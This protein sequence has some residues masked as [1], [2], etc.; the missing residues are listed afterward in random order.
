MPRLPNP[1]AEIVDREDGNAPEVA[2]L[3][4][5]QPT[6][7][8]SPTPEAESPEPEPSPSSTPAPA[9]DPEPDPEPPVD[10]PTPTPPSSLVPALNLKPQLAVV[11]PPSRLPGEPA[12]EISRL[13]HPA[14]VY[15][16]I[17]EDNQAY[18][19]DHALVFKKEYAN[20]RNPGRTEVWWDFYSPKAE[21]NKTRRRTSASIEFIYKS[22]A[23]RACHREARYQVEMRIYD[24]KHP[25]GR[26]L[27]AP[28]QKSKTHL[29]ELTAYAGVVA[30]DEGT[31]HWIERRDGSQLSDK[32]FEVKSI[33]GVPATW[34][35]RINGQFQTIL[36]PFVAHTSDDWL[37]RSVNYTFPSYDSGLPGELY[38]FNS[39]W[40]WYS[41]K[42]TGAGH[43][44]HGRRHRSDKGPY[45]RVKTDYYSD[46]VRYRLL[47]RAYD[48]AYPEGRIIRLQEGDG[49]LED[50][51]INHGIGLPAEGTWRLQE[52]INGV[53]T[54]CLTLQSRQ[55][56][57]GVQSPNLL[58]QDNQAQV[59][60]LN[61]LSSPSSYKVKN[62]KWTF[63]LRNVDSQ[64]LLRSYSGEVS[65]NSKSALSWEQVWDGKDQDGAL[66]SL[67]TNVS[68]R[69]LLEV[70]YDP[71]ETNASFDQTMENF[72]REVHEVPE[73]QIA[74]SH[75]RHSHRHSE[76]RDVFH[77]VPAAPAASGGQG[78]GEGQGPG[79]GS[80][81]SGA[82]GTRRYFMLTGYDQT[83]GVSHKAQLAILLPNTDAE[84]RVPNA[85]R[86]AFLSQT[87]PSVRV[88]EQPIR[89]DTADGN[90]P[91]YL[92]FEFRDGTPVVVTNGIP[93]Q[94]YTCG[95]WGEMYLRASDG[96]YSQKVVPSR[97]EFGPFFGIPPI[98]VGACVILIFTTLNVF[99]TPPPQ[100]TVSS[101][102]SAPT[103]QAPVV[104]ASGVALMQN[105]LNF[106]GGPVAVGM[107]VS[108]G[109]YSH[110]ETDLA[111]K[112]RGLPLTLTRY[113]H[114]GGD[115]L[116]WGTAYPL[117]SNLFRAQF[118]WI[119][120]FQRELTFADRG[121]VCTLVKP[122]G[123]ADTF[124]LTNS[125]WVPARPD[126]TDKLTQ[127]DAQRFQIETKSHYFYVF[128]LP[129]QL[130][131]TSEN[132]RAFLVQERDMHNNQLNYRWDAQGTRL[133]TIQEGGTNRT[134]MTVSW[135][136]GQTGSPDL[137][138]MPST[139]RDF[140]GR[141]VTY[142]YQSAPA[143]YQ[144]QSYLT[145]VQQP[146]NVNLTYAYNVQVQRKAQMGSL[147]V[148][149]VLFSATNTPDPTL[150]DRRK[151]YYQELA[152]Y[153]M[154][155][156][157]R[158]VS[159]N[160]VVQT[161]F[162]NADAKGI[163]L[164]ETNQ[165]N[166]AIYRR[167]LGSP[168]PTAQVRVLRIPTATPSD[169]RATDY[170]FDVNGRP[171]DIWDSQQNRRQF[172]YD[173]S[174]NLRRYI[175]ALN[176]ES[177]FSFDA[178]RNLLE[179]KDALQNVHKFTYDTRDRLTEIRNPLNGVVRCT[180]NAQDDL[181]R[182]EDED[183]AQTN[184]TY[185]AAG[186]LQTMAN[187]LSN[188]W[189]YQYDLRGFLQQVVEPQVGNVQSVW[190][191][192]N[193][194]LGR[195]TAE[196]LNGNTLNQTTYDV[197]DRVTSQ[198]LLESNFAGASGVPQ[199]RRT[200]YT[201]NNFD[202]LVTATDP[203]GR[204]TTMEFDAKQRYVSTLRP[205]G[206]RV[207]RTYNAQGEIETHFNG[208]RVST[209]Y[210]YDAM[211]RIISMFHP[212]G[213]T[214]DF[215]YDAKGRLYS[216]K[217]SDG[218]VV[219]YVYDVLDRITGI[220]HQGATKIGYSYDALG[221]V[222]E[223][224]D[225]VGPTRYTYSAGSDLLRVQD[226]FGR[227]IQYNYNLANQLLSRTDPQNLAT[228][229]TYN[230]RGQVSQA[231]HD[232]LTANYLYNALGAPTTVTWNH[233]LSEQYQ[234]SSQGEVMTRSVNYPGR[235]LESESL[236]RDGL[237]RK[238]QAVFTIP[239]GQRT[240]SYAY[241][242][243][244]ELTGSTRRI[245][246]NGGAQTSQSYS[247]DGASN[248]VRLGNQATAFNP[249]DQITSITGLPNPS[250]STAGSL[251]RDQQNAQYGYDWREQLSSY[252]RAGTNASYTYDGN[253]LR[254][255]KL[256]NG[257]TTQYLLDGG[258]VLK[259]YNGDGTTKASYFLGAT[260]R[261]AI[262]SNGQWYV[263]LRDTHGSVTG[264]VDLSGNRVATYESG[265][266]GE[267][268][269]DQG[270]VYNPY[271]WNGEPLDAESGL[272]YMRNRYYQSSTGRFVQRDPI[273]YAGG[274]NLYG[275]CSSDPINASDPSGLEQLLYDRAADGT[276]TTR[277]PR[278]DWDGDP[279]TFLE[280]GATALAI[281]GGTYELYLVAAPSA[282]YLVARW[283]TR[284][285][286][287]S[288]AVSAEAT[289][290]SNS[291]K[292]FPPG[293]LVLMAD[294][295][296][297]AIEDIREGDE[298]LANDPENARKPESKKVTCVA[299]G[300]AI[301]LIEISF[302]KDADGTADGKFKATGRHP[303]W[304]KNSGWKSAEDIRAGD[305]MQSSD[306]SSLTVV[307]TRELQGYTKT[308]NL[309][310]D[311]VHTFYVVSDGISVLVHNQ[312]PRIHGFAP[313][314]LTK[315]LHVTTTNGVEVSL[316]GGGPKVKIVP[317]FS[318]ISPAQLKEA[319]A[320]VNKWL[321]DTDWRSRVGE[322]A[323]AATQWL[324]QGGGERTGTEANA[325]ART[326]SGNT[327][328][329]QVT[330][331]RLCP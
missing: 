89:I 218:T 152:N 230:A 256:V 284:G 16:E 99:T 131:H 288:S 52:K 259:E 285:S 188:T 304:T 125:G 265:D 81:G 194:E 220:L 329:L 245:Q 190:T 200:T 49:W 7:S 206:T 147:N 61:L 307:R 167:E 107:D 312:P 155:L 326:M 130:V 87:A 243:I 300:E 35:R 275:F 330:V 36:V 262:K 325:Q 236:V 22:E 76:L 120:N 274:L 253:N 238:S 234:Y 241:N 111:L 301:R 146:G 158:E 134:L 94:G 233:G 163:F 216:W 199:S 193:D 308:H 208:A 57:V 34:T 103:S 33:N 251:Q 145:R 141:T 149:A 135:V 95:D 10:E 209:R 58:Y 202:Q 143:P 48:P 280:S 54:E 171:T 317:V 24:H 232:G 69:L 306:G 278:I 46:G 305:F 4:E 289:A 9:E 106:S 74:P 85:G 153:E 273:S 62:F 247:Y 82:G 250:Y 5:P 122:E 100:A 86:L 70:P 174:A 311:D 110:S 211:H 123:G 328:A 37:V 184:F 177:T 196:S 14:S 150:V 180:Y 15:S 204:T 178:R 263:Y 290:L 322:R 17:K 314:W 132:S 283:A 133:N 264:L 286:S 140:T 310:V 172:Q 225:Q 281:T 144:N 239:S 205:D 277:A 121:T 67:G 246:P 43:Q 26:L 59:Y 136:T 269:T 119:W 268:L 181:T 321:K 128:Q 244:G 71:D 73:R 39:E 237:G 197:R 28:L 226:G 114:S 60:R 11:Y 160:N 210:R 21:N 138:V 45:L 126:I 192:S 12:A 161:T 72:R 320:E 235:A 118:G 91:K 93:L 169:A 223:M 3:P 195:V 90:P 276:M 159:R 127:L 53:E 154:S 182:V 217:K 258:D 240:H 179:A 170:K 175:N 162:A 293:T 68:A 319:T 295:S 84:L 104:S 186:K 31:W 30:P 213:D 257:V 224:R 296:V 183:G 2:Q 303:I 56:L 294:G 248:R 101:S 267:T 222:T 302:D 8:E 266:Y 88:E 77:S 279:W 112:T 117:I 292:C 261:Q 298:V 203:L 97:N 198:T 124:L 83:K 50:A 187:A 137:W 23:S 255:R 227:A 116:S 323:G 242:L 271:R 166:L 78:D 212:G 151:T 98:P 41:P 47:V 282:E 157:L 96:T 109:L 207:G 185:T 115:G 331:S 32:T 287:A 291:P 102:T 75:F 228:S 221:R 51:T 252:Q 148:P 309:T 40:N 79:G 272:T 65:G 165:Q 92:K 316:R 219:N 64:A 229:F 44:S 38:H 231:V 1:L 29:E 25:G 13:P 254:M 164:R 20:L 113:W 297:K 168:I 324:G 201:Y 19:Q 108:S 129:D 176:Q 191:F 173:P 260:G 270:T 80:G 142:T 214:E 249:A 27:S 315:G 18:L 215:T 189:S 156:A 66:V 299:N 318:N 105:H 6:P 55:I 313:D 327:R 63:E 139:V 42:K